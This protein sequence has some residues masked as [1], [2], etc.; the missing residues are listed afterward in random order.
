MH[1][2]LRVSFVVLAALSL[3]LLCS[4]AFSNVHYVLPG[5]NDG[6]DGLSWGQA[7]A[8]IQAAIFDAVAN[9]EIWVG[10]GTY[11]ENIILKSGVALYGGFNGTETDRDDRNW[12]ASIT[13]IDGGGAASVVTFP[14]GVTS[15]TRIDGFTIQ[16][17]LGTPVGL[18]TYGGGIF[19]ADHGAPT[20]ENNVI[21][22]NA[23]TNGAGIYIYDHLAPTIRYNL[24]T[25]NYADERGGGIYLRYNVDAPDWVDP[26]GNALISEN[27]ITWNSALWGCGVAVYNCVATI[28]HNTISWN[29]PV[30]WDVSTS[31][32]G[33]YLENASAAPIED[34]VLT[35]N[36]AYNGG[37][38]L[39][40]N[41]AASIQRNR[42][43][44]NAAGFGGGIDLVYST[45]TVAN[46]SILG[47]IAEDSG[48]G[49]LCRD[50]TTGAITNNTI[51]GNV[52]D[53]AGGGLF[54]YNS[55]PPVA[56]NIIA[57]N[58]SGIYNTHLQYLAP[59]LR[60]NDVYRNT[61]YD[62]E[63][64]SPSPLDISVDPG[65]ADFPHG[66]VH[67]QPESPCINRGD[68][69]V[70]EP[71]W[72]D[73]DGQPRIQNGR[74]DIG[75]DES[76]GAIWDK[77]PTIVRVSLSGDDQNDGSSWDRAVRTV[78]AGI[79]AASVQGGE[80]WVA[81]GTYD[82]NLLLRPFVHL[83]GGFAGDELTKD[84][85]DWASNTTALDGGG[86]SWVVVVERSQ[87]VGC[88]D[89]FTIQNGEESYGGGVYCWHASPAIQ[90]N[91]IDSN[92]AYSYGGGVFCY[93]RANPIIRFNTISNNS[94][95]VYG[96]GIFCLM[97][98]SPTITNN[99]ITANDSDYDGAG[100]FCYGESAPR[101]ANNTIDNN[102][103]GGYGAA[104]YVEYNYESTPKITN[105]TVVSN[106][107]GDDEGGGLYIS[108][109]LGTPIVAN[110][111]FALN[112]S[113]IRNVYC[114]VDYHNNLVFENTLYNYS[115]TWPGGGDI[116]A[117]PRFVNSAAGDYHLLGDS[118]CIDAGDDAVVKKG[119]L[120]MDGI[121]RI[122]GAH[123]DVGADEWRGL[124]NQSLTPSSGTFPTGIKLTFTSKYDH[125][126]GYTS[127]ADCYLLINT[128]LN[129][130]GG[131]VVRYD[132]NDDKLYIRNDANTAWVGGSA[133]GSPNV[134]ENSKFQLYCTET[135]VGGSGTTLTVNWRILVKLTMGGRTCPAWMLVDDDAGL[136]DGWDQMGLLR[137]S[138]PPV[139]VSVT[140][141]SASLPTSTKL[142][143]TSKYADPDGYADLADC[144]L[145]IKESSAGDHAPY[146]RYD[147]NANKLYVRDDDDTAWL[148]G[149]SPGTAFTI[150]NSY[151]RL[152]CAQTIV[153]G[154]AST[155]TVNWRLVL[156]PTMTARTVT[157]W[158]RAR[159]DEGL[160]DGWDALGTYRISQPPSNDSLFPNRGTL[161]ATRKTTFTS[162]YSDADGY[163]DIAACFLVIN[164][165]MTGTNGIFVRYDATTNLLYLR[166]DA[167]TTWLGGY[168]PGS[169]N[170]IQNNSCQL[171]CSE[172]TTSGSGIRRT[173]NWKILVKPAMV[174]K[175][176]GAWM[177]VTD[178]IGLRDGYDKMG[179]FA[180]SL[181]P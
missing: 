21:R 55:L 23:A 153:S 125:P 25:E 18:Y 173:V 141:S 139:D 75:S 29:G 79:N 152:Y 122:Y 53:V 3:L 16:N 44:G 126:D 133:P 140:P 118:P 91:I 27:T 71:I 49:I 14:P 176:C 76:D 35:G 41:S 7:K 26:A 158:M 96:G 84:E 58:S 137:F 150:E 101:I 86:N 90:N 102:Q 40:A 117:D 89:G 136:R 130:A 15:T 77:A 143:I 167:N 149:Y 8:T 39:C 95:W 97:Y 65:L 1:H 98:S 48:A 43:A 28:T 160:E 57:F 164:T 47:N 92:V 52:A 13:V 36:F 132:Q 148:G 11:N 128:T 22:W 56:N 170:V 138:Q 70:V 51:V 116:E 73:I 32:G 180:V 107:A 172:T 31:G 159:D 110:N 165:T 67:I 112:T 80:V 175:V 121:T 5:G 111:I 157:A 166:D 151:C 168:A 4:S 174:G 145:L 144:R 82:E 20:I 93:W 34:N 68:D 94:A 115:G 30:T 103:A 171:Y 33:V 81:S 155:L 169:A 123:V 85:R 106:A 37:G 69:S 24:I 9:D 63:G 161:I 99:R 113:G 178:G 10:A 6:D 88:I 129:G 163:S 154:S 2:H 135:S 105:N 104:L 62:Y 45:A 66:N 131:I 177:L 134:L 74:V 64:L 38:I 83:Y 61:E 162:V 109:Q 108:E 59:A 60:N 120:D 147:A 142:T 12:Q 124:F 146:V 181:A 54:T 42:I 179:M 19:C 100:I 72:M 119:D 87:N 50:Y 127:L 17:G 46:N 78:Q 156:K 114:T